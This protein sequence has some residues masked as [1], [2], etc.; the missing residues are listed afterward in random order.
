MSMELWSFIEAALI[1]V[2]HGVTT[3]QVQQDL[4]V[5]FDLAVKPDPK[6]ATKLEVDQSPT[7]T[8]TALKLKFEVV[9]PIRP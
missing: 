9:V 6:D 7:P 1:E 5:A 4:K 2:K 3:G 8:A